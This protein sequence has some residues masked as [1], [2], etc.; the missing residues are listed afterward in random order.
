MYLFLAGCRQSPLLVNNSLIL[1]LFFTFFPGKSEGMR[2]TWGGGQDTDALLN[3]KP[4]FSCHGQ[5]DKGLYGML[6]NITD[7][8]GMLRNNND[9]YG[10]LSNNTYFMACLATTLIFM[11]CLATTLILL[12]A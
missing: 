11:A 2:P 8:Y 5:E 1:F 3:K 12:H 6:C 4:V 10:M 7:F 9:F